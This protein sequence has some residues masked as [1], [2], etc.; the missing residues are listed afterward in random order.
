MMVNTLRNFSKPNNDHKQKPQHMTL[1]E[2][3][4]DTNVVIRSRQQEELIIQW[5]KDKGQK[6]TQWCANNMYNLQI[7]QKPGMNSCIPEG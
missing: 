5:P 1:E 6:D 3:L 4:E 2:M 7:E